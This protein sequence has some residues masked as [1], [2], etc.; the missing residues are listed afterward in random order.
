MAASGIG[1]NEL[2]IGLLIFN[3]IIIYYD[4]SFVGILLIIMS[5]LALLALLGVIYTGQKEAGIVDQMNGR[6]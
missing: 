2:K 3:V 4:T 5:L 1:M 6:K